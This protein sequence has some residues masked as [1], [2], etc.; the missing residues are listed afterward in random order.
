MR[1]KNIGRLRSASS[2]IYHRKL[3]TMSALVGLKPTRTANVE[4]TSRRGTHMRRK[5]LSK[6]G[7]PV[8]IVSARPQALQ[9]IPDESTERAL[10]RAS[11]WLSH[12][13]EHDEP[14]CEFVTVCHT[15]NEFS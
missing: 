7:I 4:N 3:C 1:I 14:S 10:S 6:R 9:I 8:L 11:H 12:C 5:L 2:K 13:L 15:I